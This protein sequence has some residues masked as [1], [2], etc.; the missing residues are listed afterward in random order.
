MRPVQGGAHSRFVAW[1]KILLPLAAL[2]LMATLFLIAR[3]I[4]PEAAIPFAQVDVERFAREARIGGPEVSGVTSDGTIV[5]I[6]AAAARP[7]PDVAGRMTA[8]KLAARFEIADGSR[9]EARAASGTVD[10]ADQRLTLADGV[11]ISTS[12]GYRI[13]ADGLTAGLGETAL[14]SDGAVTAEGPP[15]RIEAG[16]MIVTRR[17]DAADAPYLLVFKDGVKLVYQPPE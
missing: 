10:S 9:I 14:A 4:D 16:A 15:G 7:D 6:S 8:D 11:E 13:A 1:A 17:S 2:S 5:S 12:T 3:Q